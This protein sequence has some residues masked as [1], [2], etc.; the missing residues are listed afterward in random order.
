M[1]MSKNFEPILLV[2]LMIASVLVLSAQS[3][4]SAHPMVPAPPTAPVTALVK[5]S[6]CFLPAP[7]CLAS[8]NWAG[9]AVTNETNSVTYVSAYWTVPAV[10]GAVG[11][12]CPDPVETWL[13]AAV[14]I[15][16]DGF[17]NG[18]VEQTGTSSDCVYGQVQYY[19]WFE[20]YPAISVPLPGADQVFP[21]DVM[22]AYINYTAPNFG[23]W[24]QDTTLAHAWHFSLLGTN[25]GAPRDSAEW[26]TEAAFGC[27][28]AD[29]SLGNFLALTDFG[30]VTFTH[31]TATVV[32]SACKVPGKHTFPVSSP[33]WG[34]SLY[35]ILVTNVF[36]PPPGPF[37]RAVP[38]KAVAGAFKVTWVS[39][40]P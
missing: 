5:K 18:Y 33:S 9:Y 7:Q 16:I 32:C 35:W 20:F 4:Q 24:I 27:I 6:L 28:T 2:A 34:A 14:W 23:I 31:A 39:S 10:V 36:Y 26:I 29:C 30:T 13:D 40:G 19:A 25:P 22:Y 17:S 21:R 11:T 15:G 8:I 37:V 12:T 3:I 38:N 1:S